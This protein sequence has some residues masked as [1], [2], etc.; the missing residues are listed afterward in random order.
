MALMPALAAELNQE[1]IMREEFVRGCARGIAEPAYDDYL[2]RNNLPPRDPSQ[3]E[4]V[5]EKMMQV[6]PVRVTCECIAD[7]I[8]KRWKF[9]ELQKHRVEANALAIELTKGKC[10][11]AKFDSPMS[12]KEEFLDQPPGTQ[13]RP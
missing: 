4:Q 8:Q 9:S 5:I 7:E 3:R 10:D 2:K 13:A 11:P 12:S 1:E 6:G